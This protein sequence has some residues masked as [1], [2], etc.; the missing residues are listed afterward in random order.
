[1]NL[2]SALETL[3]EI[4][5]PT[6]FLL[7]KIY[8]SVSEQAKYNMV[9]DQQPFLTIVLNLKSHA[10]ENKSYNRNAGAQTKVNSFTFI[11]TLETI[12]TT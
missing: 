4:N 5:F 8:F 1:M 9:W 12:E 11:V 7:N 3:L 2:E 6:I 10:S